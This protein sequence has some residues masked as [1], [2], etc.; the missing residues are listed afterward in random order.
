MQL[1][2][3]NITISGNQTRLLMSEAKVYGVAWKGTADSWH[4]V[5]SE[6]P[7]TELHGYL[8]LAQIVTEAER[9]VERGA[10]RRRSRKALEDQIAFDK[11]RE[12]VL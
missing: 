5:I 2:T 7:I 11:A 6:S 3:Y 9:N 12:G 4:A 10:V 1:T 8:S